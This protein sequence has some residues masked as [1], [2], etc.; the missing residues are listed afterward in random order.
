VAVFTYAN[1]ELLRKESRAKKIHRAEAIEVYVLDPAFLDALD[2][3]TDRNSAWTVVH[4]EGTLYV[5]AGG[6]DLTCPVGR[7][8]LAPQT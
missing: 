8:S 6:T 7:A 5:T 4:T 1:P 2:A 3:V